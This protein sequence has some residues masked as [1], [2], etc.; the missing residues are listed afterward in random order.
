MMKINRCENDDKKKGGND[1]GDAETDEGDTGNNEGD[2]G[3][4]EET[5]NNEGDLEIDE[6]EPRM[7]KE[8]EFLLPTNDHCSESELQ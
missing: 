3:I 1:E 2:T 5:R 7:I 4:E 6:G 8:R